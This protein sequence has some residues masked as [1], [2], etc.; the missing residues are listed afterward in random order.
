VRHQGEFAPSTLG[1]WPVFV[2]TCAQWGLLTIGCFS[3]HHRRLLTDSRVA[4]YP[5]C[6]ARCHRI[7]RDFDVCNGTPPILWNCGSNLALRDIPSPVCFQYAGTPHPGR[8]GDGRGDTWGGPCPGEEAHALVPPS[9]S[10]HTL[11][12]WRYRLWE[13][14]L[15]PH[16]LPAFN[17]S[18]KGARRGKTPWGSPNFRWHD[19]LPYIRWCTRPRWYEQ[20]SFSAFPGPSPVLS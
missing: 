4:G 16:P 7:F 18:V 1:R 13:R 11:D 20:D 9:G 17:M 15:L 19:A 14:G 8:A 2:A 10:P 12:R 5:G 6:S 3:W